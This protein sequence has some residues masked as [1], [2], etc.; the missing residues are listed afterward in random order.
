MNTYVFVLRFRARLSVLLAVILLPGFAL[1]GDTLTTSSSCGNGIKGTLEDDSGL[2]IEFEVCTDGSG[3]FESTIW[4]GSSNEMSRVE[5]DESNNV[6][7]WV[8]DVA[9]DGS[10]SQ[11]EQNTVEGVVESDWAPL[12]GRLGAV[13]LDQGFSESS[14]GVRGFHTHAPVYENRSPTS[15]GGAAPRR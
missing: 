5:A 3:G 11:S 2:T 14:L 13:L 9:M 4:D 10:L 7:M 6:D 1:A 8:A 12:A 15:G